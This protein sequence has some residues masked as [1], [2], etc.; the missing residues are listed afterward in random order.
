MKCCL[1][2]GFGVE[3]LG[4]AVVVKD[5]Q[6]VDLV[7]AGALAPPSDGTTEGVQNDLP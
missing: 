6:A 4:R 5:F 1:V 2:E 7:A 3:L